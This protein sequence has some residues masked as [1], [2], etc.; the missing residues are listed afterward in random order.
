[1]GMA[2][3]EDAVRDCSD[4]LELV[5]EYTKARLRRAHAY[6]KCDKLEEAL[7]DYIRLEAEA[8]GS[9]EAAH[10]VPRLE[11]AIKDRDEKLKGEM[12]GKLKDLGN[13]IL[14]N[15]GLS[16]DNFQFNQDPATGGYNINFVQQPGGGDGAKK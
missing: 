14:G 4:A 13:S 2:A 10:A 9:T 3:W 16:T 5:P 7:G 15:F 6:E 8:P 12:M 11:R 1:M